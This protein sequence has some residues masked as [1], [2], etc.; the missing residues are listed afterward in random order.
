MLRPKFISLI[1]AAA[2]LLSL[3]SL[4]DAQT[5]VKISVGDRVVRGA[6]IKPYKNRW[7]V[8]LATPT[9]QSIDGGVWTDEVEIIDFHGRKALRRTQ[10]KM[11]PSKPF[12]TIINIVDPKTFAP[13]MSE[14]KTADG[15]FWRREFNGPVVHVQQ[16]DTPGGKLQEFQTTFDV[17]VFDFFGGMY[18]I[19]LRTFPLKEGYSA[20]FPADFQDNSGKEFVQWAVVNV[21]SRENVNAA[22]NKQVETW[23]VDADLPSGSGSYRFWISDGPP[24][25]VKL[26]YTGPRGG[27]QI[28]EMM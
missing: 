23:I 26:V 8:T 10:V 25:I 27:K 19:L 3:L 22:P 12:E 2:V 11:N 6:S 9:G 4:V 14:S 20:T 15:T 7:K 5:A 24:Y 17:P 13:I 16:V 28:F 21:R 18:G 1:I